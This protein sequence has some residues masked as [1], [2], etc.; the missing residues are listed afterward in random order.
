MLLFWCGASVR[1]TLPMGLFFSIGW[2]AHP[3]SSQHGRCDESSALA[4]AREFD[5]VVAEPATP[6]FH[7]TMATR[8]VCVTFLVRQCCDYKELWGP[9]PTG[10]LERRG[11][12]FDRSVLR[13]AGSLRRCK[14]DVYSASDGGDCEAAS[15]PV[16]IMSESFLTEM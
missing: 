4:R 13:T 8:H 16:A 7:L 6:F 9:S 3:S 15:L 11:S 12:L 1:G 10:I 14:P 5:F 2:T